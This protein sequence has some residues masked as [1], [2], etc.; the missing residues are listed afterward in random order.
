METCLS[1]NA[2]DASRRRGVGSPPIVTS[3]PC[4]V[5]WVFAIGASLAQL[6]YEIFPAGPGKLVNELHTAER[7]QLVG[8]Y[9]FFA[10]ERRIETTDQ[11][12]YTGRLVELARRGPLEREVLEHGPEYEVAEDM[13]LAQVGAS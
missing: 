13:G 1:S 3:A 12:A 5:R 2:A 9:V 8:T 10:D 11:I 6:I 4:P 7:R